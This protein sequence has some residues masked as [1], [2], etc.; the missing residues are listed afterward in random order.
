MAKLR[1]TDYFLDNLTGDLY[2]YNYDTN[3]WVAKANAGIHYEKTVQEYHSLGKYILKAPIYRP[4]NLNDDK[5]VFTTRK[6]ESVC[7]I[8]KNHISHWLFDQVEKEFLI[9]C[10][11]PW[12]IHTFNFLNKEKTFSILAENQK[13]PVIIEMKNCIATLFEISNKYY[14]T[15]TILNNYIQNTIKMI[16][17]QSKD[18]YRNIEDYYSTKESLEILFNH[19]RANMALIKGNRSIYFNVVSK[20]FQE[21]KQE[22]NNNDQG[23]TEFKHVGFSATKSRVPIIYKKNM[24]RENILKNDIKKNKHASETDKEFFS[25]IAVREKANSALQKEK[26]NFSQ[27]KAGFESKNQIFDEEPNEYMEEQNYT[28]MKIRRFLHP[29]I[30]SEGLPSKNELWVF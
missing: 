6:T 28:P 21:L 22:Q 13:G 8:K 12:N 15:V 30:S 10:K 17:T 18:T 24:I 7:Y 3:E 29:H 20:N 14:N 27:S 19:N 4:K 16:K 25:M 2:S 26:N 1:N 9:C 11:S 5:N 23:E